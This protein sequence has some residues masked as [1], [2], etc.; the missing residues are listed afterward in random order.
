LS[1]FHALV[2]CMDQQIHCLQNLSAEEYHFYQQQYLNTTLINFYIALSCLALLCNITLI[3]LTWKEKHYNRTHRFIC[4]HVSGCMISLLSGMMF[5]LRLLVP[6]FR[7]CLVKSVACLLPIPVHSIN[8]FAD[9]FMSFCAFFMAVDRLIAV[10]SIMSVKIV[11]KLSSSGMLLFTAAFLS[12]ADLVISIGRLL[13]WPDV[14]VVSLCIKTWLV[15]VFHF[16]PHVM[17]S[18]LLDN[19]TVVIYLL[20]LAKLRRR[21][22]STDN[23]IR[24]IQVRREIIVLKKIRSVILFTFFLHNIP[25][26]QSLLNI[27][28]PTLITEPCLFD[29]AYS[30]LLT[31]FALYSIFTDHSLKLTLLNW[32]KMSLKFFS[33]KR[34]IEIAPQYSSQYKYS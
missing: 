26:M 32:L 24:F 29:I 11:N 15:S 6:E 22:L 9:D 7:L 8:F 25:S 30:G 12:S 17:L 14:L 4:G 20:A 10:R 1:I 31:I 13:L 16:V 5:Y 33:F 27:L 3:I 2:V 19:C 18:I 28:W 34:K 23:T 21:R